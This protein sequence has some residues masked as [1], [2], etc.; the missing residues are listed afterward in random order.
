M[1]VTLGLMRLRC[2]R[3]LTTQRKI[4]R[5]RVLSYV[6]LFLDGHSD[7]A[8]EM[9]S[10][11]RG[12]VWF[13]DSGELTGPVGCPLMGVLLPWVTLGQVK[14]V[15]WTASTAT[16]NCANCSMKYVR[17]P[18][19][20]FSLAGRESSFPFQKFF[21]ALHSGARARANESRPSSK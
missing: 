4:H 1:F 5:R 9:F 20:P 3:S 15:H 8:F 11:G 10:C 16:F 7:M 17:L 19:L 18:I 12:R 14:F 21:T 2:H 13:Y 6:G